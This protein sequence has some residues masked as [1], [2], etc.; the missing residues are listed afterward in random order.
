MGFRAGLNP[1]EL[2]TGGRLG[3]RQRREESKF[4]KSLLSLCSGECLG[5]SGWRPGH[6]RLQ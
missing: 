4:S 6:K 1:L 5:L 3:S 2:S